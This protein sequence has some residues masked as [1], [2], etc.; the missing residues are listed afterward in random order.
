MKHLILIIFFSINFLTAQTLTVLDK[1]TEKPL[2]LVT[3]YNNSTGES[4]I[5]NSSGKVNID[6]FRNTDSLSF[7]LTGYSKL[8][9]T[10]D[11]IK[12]MNYRVMM[13][14]KSYTIGEVLVLGRNPH[15]A[16]TNTI[17]KVDMLGFTDFRRNNDMFLDKALNLVPGVKMEVRSTTSQSHILIRGIGGKS[18]FGLRDIKVYYDGIPITDAD[19]TTSINDI[20]FTS[21]GKTEIIKGSSAGL[22][23]SSIG[24][25]INL[26]SKRAHYQEKDFNQYITIGSFGLLTSTTN[27]R[28]GTDKIN[29][30]AN[31]SYQNLDGFRLHSHSKKEF[32]TFGGDF[33]IS[34]VQTLSLLVNYAHINDEFAG[35]LDSVDYKNNPTVSNPAYPLKNI[36]TKSKSFL[37]GVSHIYK[38]T[39]AFDNTTN[40]FMGQGQAENPIEPFFN[41]LSLSKVGARSVFSINTT[42]AG[43]KSN[44]A[45]G[46]EV[47]RNFNVEKHY[48]FTPFNSNNVGS[49]NSDKE[50]DLKQFNLFALATLNFNERLSLILSTGINWS[51][52]FVKDN[53]RSNNID[54]TNEMNL[55]AIF[56][57]GALLN[58]YLNPDILIYAQVST[59][60]SPPTVSELSLSDGS[61]NTSLNPEKSLN[62]EVGSTGEFINNKLHYEVSL[63]YLKIKDSF[64]SQTENGFTRFV[65][66]GSSDNKGIEATISYKIIDDQEELVNLIRPF[67][68]YSY[69]NFKFIDYK[70]A[71]GDFSG[72][73]F[74]GVA[75]SLFNAGID[76]TTVPGVYFYAT[77]NFVAKRPLMDNNTKYDDSYSVIDLKL[78][79]RNRI[80]KDI[81]LQFYVGI[82]NLTDERYSPTIAINQG[83]L[84]PR[85]LPVYYNP[86]PGKNYY[87][88][89]NFEYHF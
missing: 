40:I 18:R 52:Y 59:G 56:T 19:G 61:V 28:A 9:L 69:N 24:G 11:Q 16:I 60:Y 22:Y 68:S 41:R 43:A 49:I 39:S 23:G 42:L 65:N 4:A 70:T 67:V 45:F 64:I 82:N 17:G 25:V 8:T 26:F 10:N 62:F 14:E 21:L 86:A 29:L 77:Y 5:T 63:F 72:N 37:L 51:D 1:K 81:T 47:I 44:F 74:T 57:P 50:F 66:A 46:G 7:M 12:A 35:E 71:A 20:D 15:N 80:Q 3:V 73:D 87:G 89:I 53:L 76:I 54:Q 13:I 38:I 30:Y 48:S 75:P 6:L 79:Y 27:F 2:S 88:A 33:F 36:G 55:D 84:S 78:G 31:Y 32:V 58:Y 85:G 34:N 83:S